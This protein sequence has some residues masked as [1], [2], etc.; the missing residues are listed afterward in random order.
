[1]KKAIF[2]LGFIICS[3]LLCFKVNALEY[4]EGID[5]SKWQGSINFQEVKNSGIEIVYIRSSVG[6]SYVDPYFKQNYNN[7]KANNLKVGIYHF[8]MARNTTEAISEARFFVSV[9]QG[10]QPDC[11]LAMDF[12]TLTD[13]SVAEINAISTTFL[14]TVKNL[15]GKEVVIYSDAYNANNIF[16]ANLANNYPLWIAEYQVDK[17]NSTNWASWIGWQYTDVGKVSGISGNV[18]RDY[19]TSDILLDNQDNIPEVKPSENEE[20]NNKVI[21]IRVVRGDTL[22]QIALDY[23]VSINDLVRWNNISNPNLIYVNQQIKIYKESNYQVSEEPQSN[24]YIV[25]KGDTLS[26]IALKYGVS[27]SDLVRWNNISNPNLI[28]VGENIRI[29]SRVLS[30]HLIRYTVKRNDTLSQIAQRYGTTVNQ[31]VQIN[32]IRN[33]NLIYTG[34]IISIP[35]DQY[36]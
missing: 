28:Y 35:I 11:R 10:L 3:Y 4:I 14:E 9:I 18:D 22:S 23:D 20:E 17:P 29:S 24:I 33:A 34:E 30:N 13:L 25:Q 36:Y 27:V 21:I 2:L 12:E 8:V 26:A 19:Y 32:H 31:L 6:N 16:D 5:V 7:A 1:M 15:S